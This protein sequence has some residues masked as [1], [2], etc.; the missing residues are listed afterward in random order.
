MKKESRR[1][2]EEGIR[3]STVIMA[4]NNSK[5]VVFPGLVAAVTTTAIAAG[6]LFL[7]RRSRKKQKNDASIDS[8][9]SKGFV[10]LDY[11]GTT[12]VYPEVLEAMIPYLTTHYGNPSSSHIAG[13]APRA[14]VDRARQQI[15]CDLLGAEP[16]DVP[17]NSCLFTACGTESDNLAIHFALEKAA[18]ISKHRN[19]KSTTTTPTI[20]HV[21]TCNVEHAAIDG[22]LKLHETA[23]RCK[24]T[25]VPVQTDGRVLAKD[26]IA[27]IQPDT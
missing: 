18:K 20:P 19:Q 21:V 7:M 6:W 3:L 27:A 22:C 4:S 11:N 10:Y 1:E 17:L 16:N 5:A 25:A 13:D 23:G 8:S 14:A 2:S 15:L 9:S 24:I 12:P 26:M